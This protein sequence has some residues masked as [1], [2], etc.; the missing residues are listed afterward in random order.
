[1]GI[2]WQWPPDKIA[3]VR[4]C[5]NSRSLSH[6]ELTQ[7][8]VT[9]TLCKEAQAFRESCLTF[10]HESEVVPYFNLNHLFLVWIEQDLNRVI[11]V[12]EIFL[13]FSVEKEKVCQGRIFGNGNDCEMIISTLFMWDVYAFPNR[14]ISFLIR[15]IVKCL[16]IKARPQD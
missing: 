14:M 9:H 3:V 11:L 15:V 1:M 10:A 12:C 16:F 7:T 6:H 4:N 2:E 8:C 13:F 5:A